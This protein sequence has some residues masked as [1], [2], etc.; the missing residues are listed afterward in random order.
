MRSFKKIFLKYFYLII[1]AFIFEII[2]DK[3]A[4]NSFFNL[5]ENILFALVLILPLYFLNKKKLKLTYFVFSYSIFSACIWFETIYY[6]LFKTKFSSSAIF[7][8][9]DSNISESKEF[10]SFYLDRPIIIFTIIIFIT[11]LVVILKLTN[12]DLK[13]IDIS[14]AKKIKLLSLFITI[15]FFLKLS[16]LIVFNA[17][18]LVLKSSMEYYFESK[19]LSIYKTNRL[20]DFKNVSRISNQEEK[21]VYVIVIGES[22][23][24]SHMGIYGYHRQTTPELNR[25]KKD[26]LIYNNVISP[27][28]YTIASLTKAL[29][30]G[31]YENPKSIHDGSIIQLLNQSGFKSYWISN[32]KPSGIRDSQV[33]NIAL[34]TYKSTFMNIKHPD[35]VTNYDLSLLDQLSTVLSEKGNKKFIFLHLLGTHLDYSKRYPESFNYFKD[36][37]ITKFKNK[38]VYKV[39]NHYDNAVK[40]TDFVIKSIINSIDK[41]QLKSFVFYFSD[42]GEE[43]YDDIDFFGHS[44]DQI[45]SKSIYEI[46]VFLWQS[47]KYKKDKNLFFIKDRK[48]M[49]DDLFHSITDLIN[50]KANEVDSTRSIFNKYFI[51][52]KRIIQDT[53]DYDEFLFFNKVN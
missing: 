9:L 8:A 4:V 44:A 32:Q 34:G 14:K 45:I 3:I 12:K 2:F 21:E 26:L 22:T 20:G 35:E 10:I 19:K 50:I 43:V 39:I 52:R 17:P 37:P 5:F 48:Y 42:H 28:T 49:I 40:Y 41:L 47:Q 29:T 27:H 53:I 38:D 1:S 25:I 30:L 18:Y 13:P 51:E 16:T 33:T 7:V 24:K 46:P 31:N 6:Y 36:T 11:S 15:L 23:S